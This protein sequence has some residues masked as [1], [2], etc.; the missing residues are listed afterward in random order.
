[1]PIVAQ[2]PRVA[3]FGAGPAAGTALRVLIDSGLD[4]HLFV[5]HDRATHD[6]D[7]PAAVPPSPTG[8]PAGADGESPRTGGEFPDERGFAGRFTRLD[9]GGYGIHPQD[10]GRRPFDVRGGDQP[11]TRWD[12][13]VLL[14][15]VVG[16]VVGKA[17]AYRLSS[18]PAVPSA[19][20]GGVFNPDAEGVYGCGVLPGGVSP[21]S[22]PGPAGG[23]GAISVT[24]AVRLAEAQARWLGEYLRGR[25]LLPPRS[26]MLAATG[27]AGA[28]RSPVGDLRGRWS[29][30]H[31]RGGV[32]AYL[33]WLAAEV[34]RGR[35]RAAAGRYPL[36]VPSL[37]TTC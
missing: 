37:L 9:S 18:P 35:A 5:T 10:D 1:M 28:S 4:A 30:P 20:F 24:D 27:A 23:T 33:R 26:V 34:R 21:G 17:A 15:G 11:V 7:G 31:H 13:V 22:G 29:R 16:P 2:L 32:D 25:Y 3:V 12:A 6:A 36:P 19:L 8:G 14:G